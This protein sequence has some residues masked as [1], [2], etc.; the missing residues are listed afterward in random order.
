MDLK[1][2]GG[3]NIAVKVPPHLYEAT[4]RFYRDV[5]GLKVL[6][7]HLPAVAFEFGAN[8]L[9]IDRVAGMSQAEI[10]LELVAGDVAAAS[11]HLEAADVVRC[12]EIEPLPEGFEGFWISSPASI[13]HLVSKANRN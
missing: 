11:E 9:W 3:R 8:Q 13:V 5:V 1:F 7:N 4:V 2:A 6:D 12:D 10:W